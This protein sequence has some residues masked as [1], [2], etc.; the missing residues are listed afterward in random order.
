MPRDTI[1][2]LTSLQAR[3][4][5]DHAPGPDR[6]RLLDQ[7]GQRMQ[8]V[9]A[10]YRR[11]ASRATGAAEERNRAAWAAKAE[12]LRRRVAYAEGLMRSNPAY[13]QQMKTAAENELDRMELDGKI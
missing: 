12:R 2:S 13:F 8:E 5:A 3:I 6:E 7:V 1:Q 9:R 4:L 10:R 11:R